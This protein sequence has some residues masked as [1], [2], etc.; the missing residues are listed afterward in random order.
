MQVGVRRFPTLMPYEPTWRAMKAFTEARTD[1]TQD[2]L[3]LLQ[4]EPV[5]TQGQAGKP[6]HV[7]FL[8]IFLWFKQTAV[9]R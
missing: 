3:W 7:C 1:T 8:E 2:E 5:F 6:E 9:G 4:H